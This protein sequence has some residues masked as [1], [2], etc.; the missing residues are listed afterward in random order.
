MPLVS[1]DV[2][3]IPIV[4][5][6]DVSMLISDE[7]GVTRYHLEAE[8]W[9]IYSNEG[10][11]YWYFPKKIHVEQL[12]SLR[13]VE[14]SIVADTAYFFVKKE[15]W[16]AIGN[17]VVKNIG[18]RVFETSELFWNQKVPPNTVNAFYTDSLVKVTEPD[19]TLVLGYNGFTA[20]QSL[21]IIRFRKV[22][23]EFNVEE[24]TDSLQQN[25]VRS[26]SI[27]RLP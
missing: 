5:T 12:D 22:K 20:D 6:K 9:D 16:R 23:G 14:G 17:V 15:L 11:E 13:H 1:V 2:Q 3:A 18:G 21:N 26:D 25:T 4:H 7:S 8:I 19:S 27:R 10:D 24:S